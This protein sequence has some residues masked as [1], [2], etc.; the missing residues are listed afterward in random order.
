MR[1]NQ[2]ELEEAIN[3]ELVTD[4]DSDV[5]EKIKQII[6]DQRFAKMVFL[7]YVIVDAEQWGGTP[8]VYG[9]RTP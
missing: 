7:G 5:Y 4:S 3:L 6:R 8:Y 2:K 1:F 9:E